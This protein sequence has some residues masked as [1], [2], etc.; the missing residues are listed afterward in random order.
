MKLSLLICTLPQRR[1]FFQSLMRELRRQLQVLNAWSE[2]EILSDDS[3]GISIGEKRNYLLSIVDG[4]YLAFIDDDDRVSPN[5]IKLLLEGI[6]TNPDAC[7]L[8]GEITEDGK[9]PKKFIHSL[10]YDSWFEQDNVYYR[11]NNHLNCVRSSIARK[12]KFPKKS[13]GEDHD[14]SKQLLQSGLIKTEYWIEDVLYY[15]DY[16]SKKPEL[17]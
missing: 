17:R 15:Y 7:S 4:D 8:I 3:Q 5:Y 6:A 9:N 1:D 11:N 12:M 14:Y 2:V 13:M 16:R 10:K